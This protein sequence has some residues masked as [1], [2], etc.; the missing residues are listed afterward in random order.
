MGLLIEGVWHPEANNKNYFGKMD[1]C[2]HMITADGSSS[3]K[4]EP[5]RYHL[6]LSL[7]CPWASRVLIFRTLKKLENVISLSIVD[8]IMGENGWTFSHNEGC[9]P[10][11]INHCKYLHQIYTKSN[12]NYTGRVSVPVLWDKKTQAIVNNESSEIIRM[13]NSE[14]NEF[15]E[16]HEDF[17]PEQLRP[18]IDAI[19]RDIFTHVNSGVYK[20]GFADNQH[21]YEQA[22]DALFNQLNILEQKLSHSRYFVGNQI[23]EADWRLFTT[24]VR[25]DPIYY[26]HFKCN[27]HLIRDYPNL[28][29]YL[30]ELYQ[31]PGIADTVN[32]DHIK[33]H[34]YLS[35]PHINP[36]KIVPKGPI[37]D[38]TSAHNRHTL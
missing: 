3:F 36:M 10:D 38:L 34:Y 27:L 18:E 25:F 1:E 9:I 23:T 15:T 4:A 11:N 35:H 8:P 14:F 12:S 21:N 7:A 31:Y 30:R 20:A 2:H 13:L 32:F 24:L 17:Y 26:L 29:N 22:F 6:Y 19:N 37:M 16:N 28:S 5:N 33:R